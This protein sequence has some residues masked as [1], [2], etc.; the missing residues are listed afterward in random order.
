MK[1]R[2]I[3][4]KRIVPRCSYRLIKIN[5]SLYEHYLIRYDTSNNPI[6]DEITYKKIEKDNFS[7]RYFKKGWSTTLIGVFSKHDARFVIR[8]ESKQCL[9][10]LWQPGNIPT[11]VRNKDYEYHVNRGYFGLLIKDILACQFNMDVIIDNKC[12][13]TDKVYYEIVHEPTH[14]NYWHFSIYTYAINSKTKEKYYLRDDVPSKNAAEVATR[15][16]AD[17][18]K[19][20]VKLS[21][22]VERIVIP[23]RLY[24]D[25][26][27]KSRFYKS[28]KCK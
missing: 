20:Y 18:L 24:C 6:P 1:H 19:K 28:K 15:N 14:C 21:D 9:T 4:P 12:D 10:Q 16:I 3:Y 25:K 17:I 2:P 7:A 13:R 26:G 27:K 5:E 22:E 23:Q 11:K 8:K